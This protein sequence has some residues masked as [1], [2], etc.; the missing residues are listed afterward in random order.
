VT[1]PIPEFPVSQGQSLRLAC[2]LLLYLFG[3]FASVHAQEEPTFTEVYRIGVDDQLQVA[4]WRNPELSVSVPV[5]PDGRISVPLIGDVMAGGRT[6]EEVAE[7]I[8]K[9]LAAYVRDP[10]VAVILTELR[11][12]EFISRVRVTGA[13]RNPVSIPYRQGMTV[14]DAVLEAGGVNEFAVGNRTRLYRRGDSEVRRIEVRL[15]DILGRGELETNVPVRP[16]D[17]ITVPERAL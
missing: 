4:V 13:V 14:L 3:A 6:P 11:S 1:Q 8:E 9:Q 2:A 16:G 15:A 12:H 10:K 5:R 17:V 7:D